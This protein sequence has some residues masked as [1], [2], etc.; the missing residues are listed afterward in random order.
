MCDP[1]Q[2]A[3]PAAG[4]YRLE[5][6]R[7]TK[8]KLVHVASA[9]ELD[10]ERARIKTP[11]PVVLSR[12]ALHTCSACQ[13]VA[14]WD[15]YWAWHGSYAEVE[16]GKPVPKFCSDPCFAAGKRLGLVPRNAKRLGAE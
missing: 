8:T 1:Q 2:R 6:G 15:E 10:E 4:W 13:K 7:P 11:F 5:W 9:T 16:D 3:D 14:P 12:P